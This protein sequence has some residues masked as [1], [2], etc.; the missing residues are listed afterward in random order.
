MK[1]QCK[2]CFRRVES[3]IK[4]KI[5]KCKKCNSIL[6]IETIPLDKHGFPDFLT[7]QNQREESGI[8]HTPTKEEK[9]MTDI[10]RGNSDSLPEESDNFKGIQRFIRC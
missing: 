10:A 1:Y 8:V 4:G 3:N 2:K 6:E 9:R 7:M 5:L